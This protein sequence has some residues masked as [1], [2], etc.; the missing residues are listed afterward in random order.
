MLRKQ[1]LQRQ[2]KEEVIQSGALDIEDLMKLGEKLGTCPYYGARR[3][4]PAADLVVLPYQSLLHSAT[5]ESLGVKLKDCVII[6]DEAHNL[7]DTVTSIHSCQ[8][9][10]NQVGTNNTSA[11]KLQS[12]HL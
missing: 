5:R 2:F 8:V 4:V 3:A 10:T 9:S 12:S 6:I 11:H 7:V 1:R